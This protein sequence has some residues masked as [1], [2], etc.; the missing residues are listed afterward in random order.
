MKNRQFAN[1]P[2]G[3]AVIFLPWLMVFILRELGPI[4]YQPLNGEFLLFLLISIGTQFVTYSLGYLPCRPQRYSSN[5]D[6]DEFR[7]TLRR[8]YYLLYVCTAL[9]AVLSFY[10]YLIVKGAS[11]SEIVATREAENAE[12]P[13][14]SLIGALVALLSGAPPLLVALLLVKRGAFCCKKTYLYIWILFGFAAMFLSGGRNP[15]FIGLLFILSFH[16]FFARK[17]KAL[18]NLHRRQRIWPLL[19]IGATVFI[20]V[21]YSMYLFIERS[22]YVGVRLDSMLD[23]LS[24][25]YQLSVYPYKSE[26][27]FLSAIYVIV[28]FLIF[29]ATHALNYF[30]DYFAISYSPM[31]YGAYT[32]PQLARLVDVFSGADSFNESRSALLVNGAYLTMPGSFYLDFG[33]LGSIALIGV[34]SFMFGRYMARFA[35]LILLQKMI[36]AY[37]VVAFVFAPIYC[38]F[39]MANG[40]SMIFLMTLMFMILLSSGNRS[41]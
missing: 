6:T 22:A 25:N 39:G 1:W 27:E 16:V 14:N 41:R 30:S 13:R 15:F 40:F 35:N 31:M 29:Y 10:D 26:S 5:S 34:L 36:F 2:K 12:G 24:V 9:F 23:T 17:L 28:V 33:F 38:V 37:L 20:A 18:L 21:V 4:S 19:A 7:S 3:M 32:F 11:L 8:F